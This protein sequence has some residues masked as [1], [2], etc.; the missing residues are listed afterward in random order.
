MLPSLYNTTSIN[1]VNS[2]VQKIKAGDFV[3]RDQK[4]KIKFLYVPPPPPP[5][6]LNPAFSYMVFT[7]PAGHWSQ[8][9]QE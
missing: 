1:I 4:T 9:E 5:H 7:L 2:F 8:C 3:S 6:P